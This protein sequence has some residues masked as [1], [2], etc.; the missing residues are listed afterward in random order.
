MVTMYGACAA[1]MDRFT[2]GFNMYLLLVIG[3]G[4]QVA[5]GL[6]GAALRDTTNARGGVQLAH[7][8]AGEGVSECRAADAHACV[9]LSVVCLR[10]CVPHGAST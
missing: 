9:C 10:A 4:I 5:T 1:F 3:R 8:R 2:R 7:A 6:S